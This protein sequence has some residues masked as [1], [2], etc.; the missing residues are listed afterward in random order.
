ML[1]SQAI[2]IHRLPKFR[3]EYQ[4]LRFRTF[5][6]IDYWMRRLQVFQL[7]RVVR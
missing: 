2:C 7:L 5:L 1:V 6:R 3:N 4:I